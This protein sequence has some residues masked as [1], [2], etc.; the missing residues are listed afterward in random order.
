MRDDPAARDGCS[1]M[2]QVRAS[3]VASCT[4]LWMGEHFRE[5]GPGALLAIACGAFFFAVRPPLFD[6]DGY[7]YRLYALAPN[8]FLQVNPQHLLWNTI[9]IFLVNVAAFFGHQTTVP[10]QIF[11]IAIN[12]SALYFLYLLLFRCSGNSL[13]ALSG[14]LLIA[15][16]PWFWYFG[17]QNRP[18][19]LAILAIMLYLTWWRTPEGYPPSG[20]RL[21]MAGL[22][23]TVATLLQQALVLMVAAA[24][25]VLLLYPRG[26][27]R[28][29]LLRTFI[30][31]TSLIV[32]VLGVYLAYAR[33]SGITGVRG[34]YHWTRGYVETVHPFQIE[35]PDSV[36]KAIIG[37]S[38]ALL[39]TR[40]INALLAGSLS[41]HTVFILYAGVG[42]LVCA[43]VG[44]LL[45]CTGSI[46]R[47]REMAQRNA[48]FM[49]GLISLLFWSIFVFS[50]EPANSH[51][52]VMDLFPA[53]V[54]LA[55]LMRGRVSLA[56]PALATVVV[57]L[58]VWNGYSN[59]RVD[60]SL[61]RNFPPPLL[62]SIRK[63]VGDRGMFIVLGTNQWYGDVNYLLLFRCL[64]DTPPNS[65][66]SILDD[67]V[68][69]AGASLSWQE[70][71]RSRIHLT[72]ESGGPVFVASHI[73]MARTYADLSGRDDPF[74]EFIQEQ[75]LSIQGPLLYEQ[76][77][78]FF[79]TYKLTESSFRIGRDRYFSLADK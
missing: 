48:L 56:A 13:F 9:Q 34:F 47:F 44:F 55:L 69:A 60:Q 33:L 49:V 50:W 15:F 73:F 7:S 30:W 23:L 61:S 2:S 78:A 75:Y 39:S 62:A 22:F 21:A 4:R 35:F 53:L 46:P 42:L 40:N 17:F 12:C 10:L 43:G 72:L 18:D 28:E 63:H 54:C 25:L 65:G 20:L 3:K 58:S 8:H 16:S 36:V 52:W 32:V 76:L 66:V 11:G 57:V 37:M 41:P 70:K 71:L 77:R 27:L 45:W 5:Y 74:A 6:G 1:L 24:A 14:E 64:K 26:V 68:L 38:G 67:F 51:Y 29:R 19:S 59:Y 31:G 79:Q